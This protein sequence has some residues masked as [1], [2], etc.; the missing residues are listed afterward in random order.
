MSIS[1]PPW[2]HLQPPPLKISALETS[3]RFA[4]CQR[5]RPWPSHVGDL[6]PVILNKV[7]GSLG[8]LR[9]RLAHNQP[10]MGWLVGLK[11][12]SEGWRVFSPSWVHNKVPWIYIFDGVKFHGFFFVEERGVLQKTSSLKVPFVPLSTKLL[13]VTCFPT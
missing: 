11:G 10:A 1:H 12:P 6:W 9:Q 4:C 5:I 2:N 8:I 7:L 13:N 3:F